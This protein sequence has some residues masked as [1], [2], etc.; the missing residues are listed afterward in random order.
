M[1]RSVLLTAVLSVLLLCGLLELRSPAEAQTQQSAKAQLTSSASPAPES[2]PDASSNKPTLEC[3][4]CHGP[5]KTLPYLGG[6]QFHTGPHTEYDVSFHAQSLN[7]RKA[8]KCLDCHIR[9]GDSTSML[10]ATDPKSTINRAKQSVHG[11]AV[12][13]GVSRSPVCTDCHG[14]HKIESP[15]VKTTSTSTTAIATD[16]CAKCHEGVALSQEFGVASER[17]SSYRDSYHGLAS[18]F[19]SKVAANCSSCHGVHNI[20]PSSDARSMISANNLPQTCGQCHVG[21]SANFASG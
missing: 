10:P 21:A 13:R 3:N 17:V 18:K 19:G 4:G 20:L 5:G 6:A 1:T 15:I 8:A 16:S 7:G 9:N 2:V 12:A 14:I 11:T